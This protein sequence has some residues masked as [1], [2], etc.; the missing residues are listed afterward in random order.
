MLTLIHISF[1]FQICS[2]NRIFIST[3]QF[4]K[5]LA[6]HRR[7]NNF[8]RLLR[9]DSICLARKLQN[10][11]KYTAAVKAHSDIYTGVPKLTFSR[12]PGSYRSLITNQDILGPPEENK[13]FTRK[14]PFGDRK[15]LYALCHFFLKYWL[16]RHG[17]LG[18]CDVESFLVV[19][20]GKTM[21][22]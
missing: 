15:I 16:S 22:R 3:Y 17:S 14:L 7:K 6:T 21:V 20:H 10:C 19:Q 12:L 13:L 11:S 9:Q 5:V 4:Y 8:F 1:I 2:Y 18:L